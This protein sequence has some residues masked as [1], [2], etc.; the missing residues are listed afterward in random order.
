[1]KLLAIETS[2]EHAS[3][4]LLSGLQML[5]Y[6]LEGHSNHSE[7]LLP[8]IQSLLAE[9]GIALTALDAIAF[10]AGPGAFTGLRLACA[11]AQG[12]AM[13]ANL[14]VVSV[15]GLDALC[16][17]GD[18][19]SILVATDAR[20]G[21][22]Y[23]AAYRRIGDCPERVTEIQCLS[24]D[25][26]LVPAGDESWFGVGSGFAAYHQVLEPLIQTRLSGIRPDAVVK[27]SALARLAVHQ[28]QRGNLLQPECAAPIYVR[29]KVAMTTAE[30]LA[31]G[32]RA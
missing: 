5:E 15:C 6:T 12:L 17:Q 1:M 28:V 10:G 27:A 11:A 19:E 13:G 2:S 32:G 29:N 14:G 4:A 18:G 16:L 7:R 26:L 3:V 8:S 9:G 21:E 25:R 22:V 24:P 31:Q 23:T 30:R 20:M